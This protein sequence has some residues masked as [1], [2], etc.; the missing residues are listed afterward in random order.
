MVLPATANEQRKRRA[1]HF[2]STFLAPRVQEK[3]LRKG[4]PTA[5]LW[6]IE[7]ELDESGENSRNGSPGLGERNYGVF[8]RAL[9][10]AIT[11]GHWVPSP[12]RKINDLIQETLREILDGESAQQKL[13]EAEARIKEIIRNRGERNP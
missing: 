5:S 13:A 8:L 6:T 9:R 10:A 11:D 12:G 1:L 4:F 3:L 2:V 7:R